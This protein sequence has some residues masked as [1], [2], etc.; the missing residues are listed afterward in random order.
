MDF[1]L[2]NVTYIQGFTSMLDLECSKT[3]II[4]I[5][6]TE[7]KQVTVRIILFILTTLEN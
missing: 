7:S 3:R 4:W 1:D 2:Y 5:L 6:P